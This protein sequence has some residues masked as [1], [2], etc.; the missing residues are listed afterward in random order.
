[1]QSDQS[2]QGVPVVADRPGSY[3]VG[4]RA[5]GKRRRQLSAYDLPIVCLL[6]AVKVVRRLAGKPHVSRDE[7]GVANQ[8]PKAI[9]V[10]DLRSWG[11]GEAMD[12]GPKLAAAEDHDVEQSELGGVVIEGIPSPLGPMQEPAL[13]SKRV[14]ERAEETVVDVHPHGIPLAE[15]A[16]ELEV[17]EDVVPAEIRTVDAL[18]LL[19]ILLL[20][21]L[22]VKSRG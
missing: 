16:I 7:I 18:H 13:V 9:S 11:T 8:R 21:V 17:R 19:G 1:M 14:Y 3:L 22:P 4:R 10:R 15:Q 20:G 5:R 12:K 6:H 2:S